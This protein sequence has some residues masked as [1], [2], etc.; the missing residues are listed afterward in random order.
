MKRG[1]RHGDGEKEEEEGERGISRHDLR[2][3]AVRRQSRRFAR[4][5]RQTI[6]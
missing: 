4:R 5:V 3:R 6:N 2:S 1:K